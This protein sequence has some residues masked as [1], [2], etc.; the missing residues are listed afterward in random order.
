[1]LLIARQRIRA[2]SM[3]L[4]ALLLAALVL[5]GCNQ[6]PDRSRE[7]SQ[8]AAAG[9]ALPT[10]SPEDIAAGHLIYRNLCAEC[11]GPD[12]EGE[13]GWKQQN[14]D[15][16]FRA[17]PHTAGGH[18]WHHA[19]PVLIEAIK[20]GGTRFAGLDVGGT[21]NMPAYGEVLTDEEIHA[22]LTYLKSTWPDDIRAMQ[23]Q[24]TVQTTIE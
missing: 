18:T 1:M 21:S 14:E 19:D 12:L 9:E 20:L 15:G 22:V 10:L 3:L 4:A 2:Q 16:S 7:S 8:P 24:Q 11:H 6:T 5:A 23:W 17:P 13:A